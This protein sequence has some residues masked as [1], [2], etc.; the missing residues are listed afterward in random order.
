MFVHDL[1]EAVSVVGVVRM[2]VELEGVEVSTEEEEAVR[3]LDVVL[4]ERH[5]LNLPHRV[6]RVERYGHT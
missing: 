5:R 2:D 4:L 6:D 1:P 3:E